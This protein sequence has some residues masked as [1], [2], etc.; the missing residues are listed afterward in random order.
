MA[1]DG[2]F[3]ASGDS[4]GRSERV[5]QLNGRILELP[6]ICYM[7]Q[8]L[9]SC[10]CCLGLT[11]FPE[12]RP[13]TCGHDDRRR[14]QHSPPSLS[15][16]RVMPPPTSIEKTIGEQRVVNHAG[17]GISVGPELD[18]DSLLAAVPADDKAARQAALSS[19]AFDGVT[20]EYTALWHAVHAAPEDVAPEYTQPWKAEPARPLVDYL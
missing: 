1:E 5:F 4:M 15:S 3:D 17:V 20:T 19:A 7:E 14:R 13:F 8:A 10:R 6:G 18:V 11:A 16:Y 12:V 2:K 9:A